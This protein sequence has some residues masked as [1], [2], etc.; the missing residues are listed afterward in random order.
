ML[1]NGLSDRL[2]EYLITVN[3]SDDNYTLFVSQVASNAGKMESRENFLPK[4]GKIYTETWYITKSGYSPPT[5]IVSQGSTTNLPSTT[6]SNTTDAEG[7][8]RMTGVDS[9]SIANLAAAVNAFNSQ[10]SARGR[11]PKPPAPWRSPE[12]FSQLRAAGKC[13]RCGK[14]GHYYKIC[15]SFTWPKKHP[16]INATQTRR[17]ENETKDKELQ[18]N[19]SGKE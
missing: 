19:L 8:T 1:S 16:E 2:T 5:N 9:I 13:T 7:D 18:N 10:N 17:Q 14:K 15:P 12:E 6:V 3:T 11:N 4:S